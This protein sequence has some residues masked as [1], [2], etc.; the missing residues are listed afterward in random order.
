MPYSRHRFGTVV[1]HCCG[2]FGQLRLTQQVPPLSS[3]LDSPCI[4]VPILQLFSINEWLNILQSVQLPFAIVPVLTFTAAPAV[5]GRFAT[6]GSHLVLCWVLTAIVIVSNIYL[7][8]DFYKEQ[9]TTRRKYCYLITSV[10]WLDCHDSCTL[11][12][13]PRSSSTESRIGRQRCYAQGALA[14]W[15]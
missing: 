8:S 6:K 13:S 3:W 10:S 1:A 7:V 15:R 14:T 9:V 5:M 12:I 4:T 11:P 2:H